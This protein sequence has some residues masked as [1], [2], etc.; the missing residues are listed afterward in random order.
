M[1]TIELPRTYGEAVIIDVDVQNDFA[2]PTGALSVRD[3]EAVIAPL[4]A[5]DQFV[6]ANNGFNI[7]TGDE[8]DPRTTHF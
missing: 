6:R 7:K 2:L 4:N 5:V 8:H 3:G 1:S